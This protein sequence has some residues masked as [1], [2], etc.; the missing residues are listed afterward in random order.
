AN[1]IWH[2]LSAR[3]YAPIETSTV[4]IR[5]TAGIASSSSPNITTRIVDEREAPLWARVSAEGWSSEAPELGAIVEQL[6]AVTARAR[7]AHC[8][9]AELN[10]LPIAAG[11]LN[12]HNDVALLAGASTIPSARRQGAQSALLRARLDFAKSLGLELAMIVAQPGSAS[13][14]NALRQGFRPVYVRS[15]W[16]RS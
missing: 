15:K 16:Q 4:L 10:G 7:G 6:G 5:A 2:S 13:Q 8:F 11:A 1:E 14:R 12:V 3:G 9:L